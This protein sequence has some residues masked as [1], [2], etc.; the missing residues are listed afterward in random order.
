MV[1]HGD[2]LEEMKKLEEGSVDCIVTDPPFGIDFQSARRI[3]KSKWK[4]KIANDKAPFIWWL[5]QAFRILKEGWAMACFTRYDVE[6][7]FRNAMEIAGFTVKAQIIWDKVVHGMG[8]LKGDFAP[9]HENVIFATKGRFTFPGKRPKS[10]IRFQRVDPDKLVHPNEKPIE[11]MS[12]LI[13]HLSKEGDT[14]LD[15]FLGAGPTGVAARNLERNFI[16]I[17]REE[18]YV[19]IA[20]ARVNSIQPALV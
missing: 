12:Y 5:P 17:E 9:C 4:P 14:V 13:D 1:I 7:D 10:V 2:C 20:E 15:P 11:V 18:E 3:D 6:D 16:G 8:D 19:K